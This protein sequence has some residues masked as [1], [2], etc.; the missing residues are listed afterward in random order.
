[1]INVQFILDHFPKP[2][3]PRTIS[4]RNTKDKQIRVYDLDQM[5]QKFYES[6]F[7]DCR[8]NAF[9]SIEKP[10]PN[11]IFI[12]LDAIDIPLNK[13][14]D[15]T[16][17]NIRLKL[18]GNPTVLW[19]GNG[20]HVY[21]PIDCNSRLKDTQ[22]FRNFDNPDNLFLRFEK[23]ILSEGHADRKNYPSLKSCLLRVPG[24]LNSKN[25]E[26]GQSIDNSTVQIIQ[27]W[28][29]YR[30][31]I[32]NQLGS[33]HLYLVS[34]TLK[35][36]ENSKRFDQFQTTYNSH[37]IRWIET[38]LQTALIDSRKYCI[39]RIL[40]PY[41][42]NIRRIAKDQ[43]HLILHVWA[44]KCNK[45]KKIDFDIRQRIDTRLKYANNYLPISFDNLEQENP[46]V[47]S[48]IKNRMDVVRS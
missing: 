15:F 39:W 7:T 33:F 17:S 1:M 30:P 8:I 11:F 10:I 28:D 4:T 47:Y 40:I 20:H 27:K 6:D 42:V 31:S 3:F 29:G 44:Q 43:I 36:Q 13:K 19:T 32:N 24:S 21:Q 14:L 16:L 9:P 18:V 26:G 2:L 41:L 45:A 23:D 12:D 25:L 34:Q 37:K 38:L 5:Y 35:T 48:T 46:Y 22:D